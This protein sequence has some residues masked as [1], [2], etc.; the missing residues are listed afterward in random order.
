MKNTY[1]NEEK[2]IVKIDPRLSTI[3]IC[4]YATHPFLL[5]FLKEETHMVIGTEVKKEDGY[6][7][8]VNAKPLQNRLNLTKARY[9]FQARLYKTEDEKVARHPRGYHIHYGKEEALW[10]KIKRQVCAQYK[11]MRIEEIPFEKVEEANNLAIAMI[12]EIFDKNCL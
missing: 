12:D 11:C 9:H 6:L 10:N 1:H 8:E 4:G 5:F 3:S 7:I 2:R